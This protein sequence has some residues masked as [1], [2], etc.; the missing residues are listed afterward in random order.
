MILAVR[1][2]CLKCN[3]FKNPLKI[4]VSTSFGRAIKGKD[5]WF[6]FTDPKYGNNL[7]DF[8]KRNLLNDK[9]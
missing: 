9:Q 2:S 4:E 7:L 6:F 5:G 1:F 3:I 8:Y